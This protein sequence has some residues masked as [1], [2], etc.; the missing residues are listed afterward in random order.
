MRLAALFLL[1]AL[2]GCG[3]KPMYGSNSATHEPGVA[4]QFAQIEIPPLPNASG[5][6]LR[7]LLID[8]LHHAGPSAD[9]RYRLTVSLH[10]ADINLGLQQNATSTRGQVRILAEF[11]LFDDQSGRTL[12]HETVRTSTGYNILVNEFGTVLSATDARDRGLEEVADE[13]TRHLAL[14]FTSHT[15]A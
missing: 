10:E 12:L 9:Y 4:N 13:M 7:N 3:F 15:G 14:Y 2:A 8:D 6:A 11:W 1:A 5:Q